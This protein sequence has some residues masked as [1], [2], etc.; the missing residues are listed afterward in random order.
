MR[1]PGALDALTIVFFPEGAELPAAILS[2][3]SR[4]PDWRKPVEERI[5]C[6]VCGL[7]VSAIAD[8]ALLDDAALRET[9]REFREAHLR[10]ACSDHWWPS[11]EHWAYVESQSRP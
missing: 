11:L 8:F 10:T 9:L 2:W 6:P 4:N 1:D 5:I 3:R 7:P